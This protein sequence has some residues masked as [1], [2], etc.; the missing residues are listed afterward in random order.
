MFIKSGTTSESFRAIRI[1]TLLVF[2]SRRALIG[3]DEGG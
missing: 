2:E 1:W 3:L